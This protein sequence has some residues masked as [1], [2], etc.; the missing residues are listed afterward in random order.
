MHYKFCVFFI[1]I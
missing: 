1:S